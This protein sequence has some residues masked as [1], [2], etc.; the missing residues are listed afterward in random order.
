[1]KCIRKTIAMLL[2]V[3]MC[4][5]M[6][7]I[8]AMAEETPLSPAQKWWVDW[9]KTPP[10][11]TVATTL[12]TQSTRHGYLFFEA[13]ET[14]AEYLKNAPVV[15]LNIGQNRYEEKFTLKVLG[16]SSEE[17]MTKDDYLPKVVDPEAATTTYEPYDTSLREKG[18]LLGTATD[19]GKV[20]VSVD[21]SKYIQAQTDNKYLFTIVGTGNADVRC[22]TFSLEADYSDEAKAQSAIDAIEPLNDTVSENFTLPL[23][24]KYDTSIVW[25]SSDAAIAIDGANAVVTRPGEEDGDKQVTLTASITVGETIKT[26]EFIVTVPAVITS[27][28]VKAVPTADSYA[29]K[30][31][32]DNNFNDTK[33]LYIHGSGRQ[34]LIRFNVMDINTDEIGEAVL[35]LHLREIK[36]PAADKD[37]FGITV[38]GLEG[39]D[40]TSWDEETL[41]YNTGVELGLLDSALEGY[42]TGEVIANKTIKYSEIGN[43][44]SIDITDYIK[45]QNDG[46]YALRIYG[47]SVQAYFDTRECDTQEHR[48]YLEILRGDAG[49]AAN[50][51]NAITVPE[52]TKTSFTVPVTGANGSQIEWSAES[53]FVN[54]NNQDGSVTVQEVQEETKVILK[55]VITKGKYTREKEF[56]V[57]I[58]PAARDNLA[59]DKEALTIPNQVS[60]SFTLP[61]AGEN[62]SQIIWTAAD[63]ALIS[64]EG[65]TATPAK[66]SEETITE[67]TATLTN[68]NYTD[69]KKFE[70]TIIPLNTEADVTADAEAISISKVVSSSFKVPVLGE[71]GSQIT[72]SS[73]SDVVS[74]DG[75]N[76]VVSEVNE[77]TEVTLT[78]VVKKGDNETTRTFDIKIVP[79][80]GDTSAADAEADAAAI[81]L[82]KEISGSFT[83]P[84]TG[85][86][87]SQITWSSDSE[88]ITIDGENAVVQAVTAETPATLTATV[89]KGT[90]VTTRSF[91]VKIVPVGNDDTAAD[92][93][94]ISILGQAYGDFRLPV[95]GERG[96]RIVW[97]SDSGLIT[98]DGE[99]AS[100]Q[101]VAE[102][103]N[104]VLTATVINGNYSESKKFHITILPSIVTFTTDGKEISNFREGQHIVAGTIAG[105]EFK[106]GEKLYIA[107]YGTDGVLLHMWGLDIATRVDINADGQLGRIGVFVWKDNMM[108]SAASSVYKTAE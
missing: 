28:I 103:T 55:A 41:T 57:T 47:D 62:G 4:L 100:V 33:N 96:S 10:M 75:E 25:T 69:T 60:E 82:P 64:I 11:V 66:V 24:G 106:D 36:N 84:L 102:K 79:A 48:P 83:L 95:S 26:K 76:A 98:I 17:S 8:P 88:L 92:M 61:L 104:V 2:A 37:S 16:V 73:S 87:G 35:N 108:P 14:E 23:T 97:T 30:S 51:A 29:Q 15:K 22:N 71:H 101:A 38:Y 34:N 90:Y 31:N 6:L 72:W 18:D 27:D 44:I 68:G 12:R 78:A 94:A 3:V 39:N 54:V 105:T 85:E 43:V 20:T 99:N 50:D 74:F 86:N 89:T 45:S 7:S 58:I 53:E 59:A 5:G 91:N 52:E 93:A 63:S 40:K 13:S 49:A 9:T 80:G 19:T 42:G 67:L 56:E 77:E 107:T 46:I 21:V 70:I 1:M 81:N 65:E 32:P